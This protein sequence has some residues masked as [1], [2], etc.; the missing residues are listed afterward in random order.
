MT[1][2]REK[3]LELLRLADRYDNPSVVLAY[4]TMAQVQAT[5]AQTAAM[6]RLLRQANSKPL[7]GGRL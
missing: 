3:A 4:A 5:L 1:D 2:H 7:F 6:E